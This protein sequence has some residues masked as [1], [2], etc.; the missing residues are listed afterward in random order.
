MET[1]CF[2]PCGV[3]EVH[4]GAPKTSQSM[5]W[6]FSGAGADDA[7]RSQSLPFIRFHHVSSCF[8][9]FSALL[10]HLRI[11]RESPE[12]GSEEISPLHQVQASPPRAKT[13]EPIRFLSTEGSPWREASPPLRVPQVIVPKGLPQGY[14]QGYPMFPT[15]PSRVVW[16][17]R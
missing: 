2:A 13:P 14:P 9:F 10:L 11:V 3:L 12:V 7:W 5:A 6:A 8:C 1:H 15:S 16:I 4:Y 17:Q